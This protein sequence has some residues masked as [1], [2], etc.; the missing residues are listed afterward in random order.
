[1]QVF[2]YSKEIISEKALAKGT[3][4]TSS[5]SYSASEDFKQTKS[6]P[7]FLYGNNLS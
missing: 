7:L 5:G 4:K 3:M 1:M 6:L 2:N